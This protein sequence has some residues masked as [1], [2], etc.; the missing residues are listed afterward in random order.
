MV[1]DDKKLDPKEY[2]CINCFEDQRIK[3]FIK[4][5]GIEIKDKIFK[6][7]FC[8][9]ETYSEVDIED[10]IQE[11]IDD[12]ITKTQK[13]IPD[14]DYENNEKIYE[15][16]CK[17]ECNHKYRQDCINKYAI[18]THIINKEILIKKLIEVI[19]N[20]YEHDDEHQLYASASS[21][22]WTEGV[23]SPCWIAGLRS[24]DEICGD[25]FGKDGESIEKLLENY[26]EFH[27]CPWLCRCFDNNEDNRFGKWSDFC[28]NVKYKA[29]YFD[30]KEFKMKEYLDKFIPFFEIVKTSSYQIKAF[31][32]RPLD[33]EKTKKDIQVEPEKEL[34]KVPFDKLKYT[35]NNRFSPV[36][37]SYGYYSF[38][39]QTILAEIRANIKD[40]VAIGE[41][42]LDN[43]L[44][45]LDFRTKSLAK[46]KNAFDDRFNEDIYCGE[47]FIL[48]FLFDISKPI[49]EGDTL[50][51]YVP[52]QIMA[53]YIWSLGKYDGFI[54]DSSQNKGCK[55]LVL[56]GDNPKYI[57]HKFIKIKEKN[58]DYK[59]E[60]IDE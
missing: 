30:H 13:N 23:D 25:I 40:E 9:F 58:I 57:E 48:D 33:S 47:E 37:I 52:T 20:L 12:C 31:R 28:E 32:A 1:E 21:E 43:N 8:E 45:I 60:V 34:G 7:G 10:C 11:H 42:Q 19:N 27:E 50:L 54:F 18:Q 49:D 36:G 41:F 44:N 24:T 55:N 56:F 38:D 51:E 14:E 16:E 3:E 35:K 59:Y 2:F 29:R 53:E 39:R 46:H 17:K 26:Y 4:N 5:N 15:L 22:Y 6:C